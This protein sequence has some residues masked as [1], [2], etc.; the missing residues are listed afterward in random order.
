MQLAFIFSYM[1]PVTL[2]LVL[3]GVVIAFWA[4]SRWRHHR[5]TWSDHR[6]TRALEKTMR[7]TRWVTF[8]AALVA[9]AATFVYLLGTGS[10]SFAHRPAHQSR[11][12][13]GTRSAHP[14]P[15]ARPTH[16]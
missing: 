11:P 4:G 5:R 16:R 10:I 7:K 6:S 13:T 9:V 12:G 8:R 1:G 14:Y 2:L 15:S 3:I